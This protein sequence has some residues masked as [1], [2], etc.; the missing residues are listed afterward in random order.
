MIIHQSDDALHFVHS[1][2][3]IEP[4]LDIAEKYG[5]KM[6]DGMSCIHKFPII[7]QL[8]III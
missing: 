3:V 8:L 6:I 4:G 1:T 5:G 7:F 2:G